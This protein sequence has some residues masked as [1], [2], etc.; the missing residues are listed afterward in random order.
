MDLTAEERRAN[1]FCRYYIRGECREGNNCRFSHDSRD[2]PEGR[3][4]FGK[5]CWYN[6]PDEP[7][8]M[9]PLCPSLSVLDIGHEKP[10]G[11]LNL[12]LAA[13][14]AGAQ[15]DEDNSSSD[16]ADLEPLTF[17][18]AMQLWMRHKTPKG[19]AL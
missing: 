13:A 8:F 7:Q 1:G 6:H 10:S 19:E 3:C 15:T 11:N 4:V 9:P 14:V 18:K 5:D 17:D 12:L 2:V 16:E